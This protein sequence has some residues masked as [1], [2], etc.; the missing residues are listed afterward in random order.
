MV[1]III[2]S[3]ASNTM[4]HTPAMESIPFMEH[5]NHQTVFETAWIDNSFGD[6]TSYH[7]EK[8]SLKI[9][10]R[11]NSTDRIKVK[12]NRNDFGIGTYEWRI[13]VPQ[14][15]IHDQCS[16]GAFIYH[17]GKTPFEI[18]FEIRSGTIVDRKRLKA[19]KNE[20]IVHCT[21]QYAPQASEIF[22]GTEQWH[23]FTLVLTENNNRYLVR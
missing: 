2:S 17:S 10:T 22:K 4:I 12:T 23:T 16:I 21:S 11:A 19:K 18:D 6:P 1:L 5:F 9:T 8:G 14:F 3:C 13:Y 20:S 7:L 15:D